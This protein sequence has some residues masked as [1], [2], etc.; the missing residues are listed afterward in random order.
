MGF[1]GSAM[2]EDEIVLEREDGD[3][4]GGREFRSGAMSDS[5]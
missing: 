4:D 3:G 5:R 2:L 1:V